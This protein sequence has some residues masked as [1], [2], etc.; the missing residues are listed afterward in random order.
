VS[1]LKNFGKTA[2]NLDYFIR[3]DDEFR[4]SMDR[5]TKPPVPDFTPSVG[6]FTD[7]A[8]LGQ[9]GP[10]PAHELTPRRPA[11][12]GLDKIAAT[13]EFKALLKAKFQI[14]RAGHGFFH[15]LLFRAA[16]AG[17]LQTRMDGEAGL[18]VVNLAT[19]SRSRNSSWLDRGRAVRARRRAL[20]QNGRSDPL[21]T[22]ARREIKCRRR[23]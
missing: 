4:M 12:C 8:P 15:R 23:C 17:G 5:K 19:C 7:V 3:I 9:T 10:K 13:E 6:A 20:R 16:G 22:Q 2:S 14:Y 1:T 21:E 11:A 18:R